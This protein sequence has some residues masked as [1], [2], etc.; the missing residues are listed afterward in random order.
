MAAILKWRFPLAKAPWLNCLTMIWLAILLLAVAQGPGR[1]MS[2]A[3]DDHEL[4]DALGVV[5]IM[6]YFGFFVG[7]LDFVGRG[8]E[9]VI[10]PSE[11]WRQVSSREDSMNST[12]HC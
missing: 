1:G 12:L 5:N 10:S 3:P 4:S 6:A 11:L 9:G 8:H 7:S 2:L